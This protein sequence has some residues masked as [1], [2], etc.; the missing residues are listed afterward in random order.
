MVFAKDFFSPGADYVVCFSR[1]ITQSM[2]TW[3]LNLMFYRVLFT[4]LIKQSHQ[5]TKYSAAKTVVIQIL[6]SC[7]CED[8]I[9]VLVHVNELD[10]L[11]IYLS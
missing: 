11:L 10:T 9:K 7:F 1:K 5:M 8:F 6:R 4:D 3:G 2:Y